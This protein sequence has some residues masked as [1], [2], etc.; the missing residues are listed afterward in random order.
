M[1]KLD[2]KTYDTYK[3]FFF[4]GIDDNGKRQFMDALL[5]FTYYKEIFN[6]SILDEDKK[7]E[8]GIKERLIKK[9]AII[10]LQYYK[11]IEMNNSVE[12][13]RN[14][15]KEKKVQINEMAEMQIREI[16]NRKVQNGEIKI[17]KDEITF[18]RDYM[19]KY[20]HYPEFSI[21]Q[22]PQE[23]IIRNWT[24]EVYDIL[25]Y[26]EEAE[27]NNPKGYYDIWL[28]TRIKRLEKNQYKNQDEILKLKQLAKKVRK[29]RLEEKNQEPKDNILVKSL[30]EQLEF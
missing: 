30:D 7:L 16:L 12:K 1:Y 4:F 20:L 15:F 18:S 24:E 14:Y 19:K 29:R 25:K 11:F 8:E 22:D 28:R 27:K 9:A 26:L 5:Y 2:K 23:Y 3:E 21:P 17:K 6:K 13:N 10:Y